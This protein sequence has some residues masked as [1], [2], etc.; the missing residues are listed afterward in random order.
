M[1]C[2]GA[3]PQYNLVVEEDVKKPPQKKTNKQADINDNI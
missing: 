1:L 2:L 3:R